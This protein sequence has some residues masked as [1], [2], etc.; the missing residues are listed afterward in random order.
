MVVIAARRYKRGRVAESQRQLKPKHAAVESQR[1]FQIRH[2]QMDMPNPCSRINS[3]FAH[4]LLDDLLLEPTEMF[5]EDS[6]I[7][8]GVADF[9]GPSTCSTSLL[10]GKRDKGFLFLVQ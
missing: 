3:G 7:S 8:I 9:F 10:R 1:P 2:L 5:G 4:I 6:P